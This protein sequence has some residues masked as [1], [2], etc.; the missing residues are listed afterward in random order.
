MYVRALS[1]AFCLM[2]AA[3][4][5]SASEAGK[6][7][8]EGQKQEKAGHMAQAYLLYARA[9]ALEPGNQIYWLKSQAVQGRAAREAR[10][11]PKP[12]APDA[13]P[14]QPLEAELPAEASFDPPDPKDLAEARKPLPPVELKAT[15]GRKDFNLQGDAKKLFEQV[16]R[17]FGLD[18]VFDGDYQPGPAFRFRMDAADHREAL[19]A[20]E[21]STASFIVPLTEKLFMVA[22]DTTQKRAEMEPSVAVIVAL[23]DP[24]SVQDL[25][26]LITA[27]QQSMGI[28]KVA[29]DTQNNTV[30][31]RDV[32]SKV[33]PARA[34]L[35]DL[36]YPR[37][38]VQIEMK[39]V[40]LSRLD[41]M[42]YGFSLPTSFPVIALT[43]ALGNVPTT[44]LGIARMALF[45]GGTTLFG[46]GIVD[47]AVVANMT[48]SSGK[49]LLDATM[50]SIDGQPATFHVGDRYP[51]MTAGYFGPQDFQGPDAYLPPPS[52]TFE[53]LGFSVK[54]TPRVHGTEAVTLDLETEFKLLAGQ[55]VNG[56]PVISNRKLKSVARLE[57]GEWAVVAGLMQAS[58][59]RT[60]AGLAGVSTLPG[61]GPLFSVHSKTKESHQVLLLLRPRLITLPPDQVVTRTF[62]VGSDTRPLTPL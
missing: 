36:L 26:G 40:E 39:F 11:M 57:M 14:A 5:A 6:V 29:W 10:A 27:V 28:Q 18:C 43:R 7:F 4:L 41:A 51:V 47:A 25:T 55:S 53:D 61:I 24:T 60:I 15:P 1:L 45:G 30:V 13:Q 35:E 58:E 48:E 2:L 42:S 50:R 59:A 46:L 8:K 54:V 44:P 9:A 49:I 32:I 19:H 56:I 3:G 23:P 31:M 34:L 17:A 16:A 20:L 62:R 52:Y 37:A 12:L 33:L 22:K 38:Q 21:A